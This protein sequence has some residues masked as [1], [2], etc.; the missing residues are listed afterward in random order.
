M[1]TTV[2]IQLFTYKLAQVSSI[3]MAVD[4]GGYTPMENLLEPEQQRINQRLQDLRV[5]PQAHEYEPEPIPVLN[6]AR[7][8]PGA[9]DHRDNIQHG[10]QDHR[11]N[12]QHGNQDHRDNIQHGNQDH[13]DNIQHGNQDHRDNPQV[14]DQGVLNR[15][16]TR[17]IAINNNMEN[18][19]CSK[20]SAVVVGVVLV[21]V[22]I[23]GTI[24]TISVVYA[25][26]GPA[27]LPTREMEQLID[28]KIQELK[29]E[30][31]I[32]LQTQLEQMIN[33]YH[34]TRLLQVT[35]NITSDLSSLQS[36]VDTLTTR[37]NSP[38]NLYKDCT[39]E[40]RSCDIEPSSE[41]DVRYWRY[42][43]TDFLPINIT[44]S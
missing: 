33:E 39:Q 3:E 26:Q 14:G 23:C 21:A 32:T 36:S 10:N 5:N 18:K 2:S 7:R 43:P 22:V 17:A 34:Q 8:Q 12:I 15:Y 29:R 41:S 24:I 13:R 19:T 1:T 30:M 44:V 31:N 11:D 38:V 6:D 40:T 16:A 42:C 4:D 9:Q 20:S 27:T 25:L 28:N 35:S 37:V